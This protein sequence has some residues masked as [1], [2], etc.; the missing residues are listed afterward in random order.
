M[1]NDRFL[2]AQTVDAAGLQRLNEMAGA[3]A[4]DVLS[5]DGI[6]SLE[7]TD[8]AAYTVLFS[9]YCPVNVADMSRLRWIQLGSHGYS[10]LNGVRLPTRPAVTNGSGVNDIPIA[11]WCV[12]M[13]LSFVRGFP[14]MLEAQRAH[15]WDRDARFQSELRGRRVGIFGYGNIGREINLLA[16][17]LGLEVWVCARPSRRPEKIRYDPLRR[18]RGAFPAPARMFTGRLCDEFLADLD[19]LVV[20]VPISATTRGVIDASV[21]AALPARAV[22]LNPARAGVVDEV[23]LLAALRSGRIAGAALD[24]HYRSPMPDSDPFFSALNTV[25]T[26]HISGSSASTWFARRLWDLFTTNVARYRG[27]EELLNVVDPEDLELAR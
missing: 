1:E 9:D 7:V 14:E 21:L 5:T 6:M 3:E 19:F 20:A 10:Q 11:E 26:S 15:R 13:M 22:V 24:D 18:D 16:Q 12:M 23:A 4:V 25:V 27:G 2:I 8:P 17:A